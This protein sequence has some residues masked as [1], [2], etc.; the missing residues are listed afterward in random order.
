METQVQEQVR[1]II[2][3]EL[4]RSASEVCS[5]ASLRKDLG[6]DSVA[7]INIVFAIEDT[8]GVHVPETEFEHIDDIDQ[9]VRLLARYQSKA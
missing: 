1:R 2:A 7:A 4:Q 9:I 5:G 3:V 8:F 6:M